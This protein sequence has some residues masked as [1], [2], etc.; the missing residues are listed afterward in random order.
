MT[1]PFAIPE[2]SRAGSSFSGLGLARRTAERKPVLTVLVDKG[3]LDL[4]SASRAQAVAR[5]TGESV[6]A[7]VHELALASDD[8]VTSALADD[9][10][11]PQADE[12]DFPAAAVDVGGLSA[13]FLRRERALPLLAD[14]QCVQLGVV[15]PT[16]DRLLEAVTFALNLQVQLKLISVSR[17]A[18]EFER[19]YGPA[20]EAQSGQPEDDGGGAHWSDDAAKVRDHQEAAPAVRVVGQILET[21]LKRGASDIHI[22]PLPDRV[23]VRLRV[24]GELET[25]LEET[26]QLAGPIAARIKILA[27]MD[28]ADRRSAQD[29]R[30]SLA[31]MGR[32]VDV[33][34]STV[35]GLHGETVALRLLRRDPALLNLPA[36]GFSP[37]VLGLLEQVLTRR[38]G[39]FL[40][41][42]PTGSGKTTTLYAMLQRLKASALKILS[43]EDPVEYFFADMTQ[44]QVNEDAGV[45]FASALRS[46][47]RQDPDVILVGEIRDGETARIAIQ[48]ALTGHLVLATLHTND[49]AGAV[50]RLVDMGVDRYLVGATLTAAI[51]QRLV[52]KL[53]PGCAKPYEPRGFEREFLAKL[54][55]WPP[56][57]L[58]RAE[59][60]PACR[61]SGV[62]GRL[63]LGEGF[64]VTDGVREAMADPS[65][66]RM[67]QAL[68][69]EGFTPLIEAA[70]QALE[71]GEVSLEDLEAL[72][73]S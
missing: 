39:L 42:G 18:S 56:G 33:R 43:V 66:R 22:E 27:N 62:G 12:A 58:F 69:C 2:P 15:D 29:G 19:L 8:D 57:R 38:R 24:D 65:G 10:G 73:L 23:R 26:S 55:A 49:A 31:A 45:T 72:A 13:A 61:G 3:L 51:S 36:L 50:A 16:N 28:V 54:S 6:V 59:G 20:T 68:A 21:A 34:I 71:A 48:A 53:C 70:V 47:L 1:D 14:G 40:V 5:K 52:R 7:V 67:A 11:V 4:P 44:T 30:T 41:T 9:F 46:F 32:P 63:A 37:Q 35:P 60:C 64:E 25:I 17:W